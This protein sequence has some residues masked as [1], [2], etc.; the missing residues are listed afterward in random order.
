M[1]AFCFSGLSKERLSR[2]VE[3]SLK[4]VENS[5]ECKNKKK[6]KGKNAK[7][8]TSKQC[9]LVTYGSVSITQ[10]RAK[11]LVALWVVYCSLGDH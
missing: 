8:W 5:N 4:L 10:H 7:F 11:S 3:F 2:Q 1:S 9:L 6:K